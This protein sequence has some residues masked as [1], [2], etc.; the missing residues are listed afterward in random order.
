MK[1]RLVKAIL[2]ARKVNC[3]HVL[4]LNNSESEAEAEVARVNAQKSHPLQEIMVFRVA[5]VSA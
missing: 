3:P 4:V 5:Y 2:T 1:Q